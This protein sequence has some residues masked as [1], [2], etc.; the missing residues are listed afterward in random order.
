MRDSQCLTFICRLCLCFGSSQLVHCCAYY[1]SMFLSMLPLAL[2]LFFTSIHLTSPS[3]LTSLIHSLDWLSC[4]LCFSFSGESIFFKLTRKIYLF[5]PLLCCF[6][7]HCNEKKNDTKNTIF[8][9]VSFVSFSLS[10][11]PLFCC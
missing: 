5:L 6:D 7:H 11:S 4:T 10:L 8:I 2:S 3:S 1:K 9:S